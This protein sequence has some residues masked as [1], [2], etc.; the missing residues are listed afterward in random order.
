MF[1]PADSDTLQ[2]D[3]PRLVS[4][5]VAKGRPLNRL[6]ST[7]E[8]REQGGARSSRA[9]PSLFFTTGGCAF[10]LPDRLAAGSADASKTGDEFRERAARLG[11]A[12][13]EDEGEG[14]R[15]MLQRLSENAGFAD[16]AA[17]FASAGARRNLLRNCDSSFRS[18]APGL[19]C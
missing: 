6:W 18:A 12:G 2:L 3:Q 16:D 15:A 13:D 4:T 7:V 14:A 10:E 5:A 11:R 1:T 9:L 17:D 8:A 19:R